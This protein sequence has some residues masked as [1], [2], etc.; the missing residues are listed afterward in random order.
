MNIIL[1]EEGDTCTNTKYEENVA[2]QIKMN[3]FVVI[4]I[5]CVNIDSLI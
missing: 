4:H 5:N 3:I 1:E 2:Y